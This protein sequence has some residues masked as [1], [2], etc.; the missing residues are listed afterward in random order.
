M[1]NYMID[2]NEGFK[3]KDIP[4]DKYDPKE[5]VFKLIDHKSW[6]LDLGCWAGRFGEK[7]Q[8]EKNCFVVGV[9]INQEAIRLAKGRLKKAVLADLNNPEEIKREIGG[10]KFDY[11][12]LVEVLEHLASPEKLLEVCG[13]FLG[14]NGRVIFSVP[15]IA[16]LPIRLGLLLGWFE[17]QKLGILDDTHLRFF[18]HKSARKMAES[19]GYKIEQTFY[20]RAKIIPNLFACSFIFV[21][22]KK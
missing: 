17:Y 20:T 19:C 10:L 21:C 3:Y 22:S 9:D 12:T 18:T 4:W 13:D 6:V 7:L 14:R 11:I 5:K 1:L 16:F 8:K 15:N 2:S